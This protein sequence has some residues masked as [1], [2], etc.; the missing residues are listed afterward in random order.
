MLGGKARVKWL[1]AKR[2]SVFREALGR[3]QRDGSK[4]PNIAIVQR[5]AILQNELERRV[6]TLLVR[7]LSAVDEQRSGKAWL[8]D[9][10]VSGGQIDHDQLRATPAPH[11]GRSRQPFSERL[12]ADF[13]QNVRLRDADRRDAY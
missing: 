13:A 1:D 2:R 11:D 5:A 4:A 8:N 10:P 3:H 7:K 6:R 12:D 9:E